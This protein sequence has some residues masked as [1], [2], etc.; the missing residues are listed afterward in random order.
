M[1][2]NN[3]GLISNF[4]ANNCTPSGSKMSCVLHSLPTPS[5]GG[6]LPISIVLTTSL[7]LK[8]NSPQPEIYKNQYLPPLPCTCHLELAGKLSN[9][10]ELLFFTL[11]W[12][13]Y[14]LLS[15]L[16]LSNY[17]CIGMTRRPINFDQLLIQVVLIP[18][19]KIEKFQSQ[20]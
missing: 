16:E 19:G 5:Q 15:L 8:D 18:A 6:F 17:T 10:T 9:E 13:Y 1:H 12:L 14:I 4:Q 3:E 2:T 7:S 11:H 20:I